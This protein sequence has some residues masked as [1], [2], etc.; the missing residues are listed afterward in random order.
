MRLIRYSKSAFLLTDRN[1]SEN[2]LLFFISGFRKF[3]I[4]FFR[5]FLFRFQPTIVYNLLCEDIK[6]IFVQFEALGF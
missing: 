3:I 6:Q 5:I 2:Q 1:P 4:K